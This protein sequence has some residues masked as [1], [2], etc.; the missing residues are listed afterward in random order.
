M[1]RA[2]IHTHTHYF[3]GKNTVEEMYASARGKNLKYYGF[4]EHTPLPDG[5]SCLLY[6]EGDMHKAFVNYVHD[7]LALKEKAERAALIYPHDS[8]PIVLLG[9][10]LDFT[11]QYCDFMDELM[12]RYPFDYVIGTVHFVDGENIGLW[13][14]SI[15][16]QE[17]QFLF[18]EKYYEAIA[19]LAKWGKTD[20]VAHPDFVKIHCVEDFTKWLET[21]QAKNCIENAL[22]EVRESGMVLEVSSGGLKK[23]CKEIHPSHRIMEIA[24]KLG[25]EISFA[26][27]T[28]N[29]STVAYAFDELAAF[30]SSYGYKKH[31]IFENRVPKFLDF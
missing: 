1:I 13:D 12:D 10:E 4:S 15:A 22:Y 25:L 6:R 14:P 2:D 23:M 16:S 27:D 31:V 5:I 29:T 8:W 19:N 17:E 20:I 18:F 26:S 7:V 24:S 9:M 21:K 30:A 3:H 11:P 28:H